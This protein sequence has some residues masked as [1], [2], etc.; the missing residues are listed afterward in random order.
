[1]E[2]TQT[3]HTPA[4]SNVSFCS[5][6]AAVVKGSR[7]IHIFDVIT[8]RRTEL[9]CSECP[10]TVCWS[11]RGD[12]L[13]CTT[14]YTIELSRRW[15]LTRKLVNVFCCGKLIRGLKKFGILRELFV[16]VCREYQTDSKF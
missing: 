3:F 13:L 6:L 15:F 11:P 8:L 2:G 1:M 4:M 5:M 12:F 7:Q 14:R 16:F 9:H 10:T